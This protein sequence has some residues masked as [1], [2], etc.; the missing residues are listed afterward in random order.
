[1]AIGAESFAG[2]MLLMVAILLGIVAAVITYINSRK[3]K[4]DVFEKPFIY[5]AL[6]ILLAT[7]SL[8]ARHKK[9]VNRCTTP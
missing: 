5:L 9:F 3:L 2:D 8:I 4:G 6:G 7:V 1:M